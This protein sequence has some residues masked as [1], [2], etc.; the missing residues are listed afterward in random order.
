MSE[1]FMYVSTQMDQK[2]Y[3]METLDVLMTS[4]HLH[5]HLFVEDGSSVV[6]IY[7]HLNHSHDLAA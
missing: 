5:L 6:S 2:I 1:K 3:V 4:L 7:V